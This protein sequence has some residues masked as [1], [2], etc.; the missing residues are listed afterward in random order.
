MT[1]QRR[2][3]V[4]IGTTEG[5]PAR[6]V[7][8]LRVAFRVIMTASSL[9]FEASIEVYNP[10]PQTVAAARAPNAQ[11]ILEAGYQAPGVVFRG[12][13]I[14]GGVRVAK[15]G[16]DRILT[17]EAADSWRQR[18]SAWLVKTYAPQT[19]AEQVIE[20]C[21]ASLG[22]DVGRVFVFGSLIYPRG[23]SFSGPAAEVLDHIA[24]SLGASWRIDGGALYFG[25]D[26]RPVIAER[27]PLITPE[28]GLVGSPTL[29][30][31][32][33][34]D[35]IEVRSLLLPRMRPGRR[36]RVRSEVLGSGARDYTAREVMHVG[37]AGWDQ[38]Y[39]TEIL[40]VPIDR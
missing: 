23:V 12:E 3:A 14:R 11:I 34:E 28:T 39:Y 10:A 16:P 31:D 30:A 36:F 27:G 33:G 15:R 21:A 7:E 9:P 6:R 40:G 8:G 18:G 4:T 25:P 26:D 29:R 22:V 32:V 37:D 35:A 20:D 38:P 13:P 17:I 5:G 19:I 24:E 2:V 1:Y